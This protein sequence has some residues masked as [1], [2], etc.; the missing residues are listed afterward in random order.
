MTGKRE[1][2]RKAIGVAFVYPL[3]P[4]GIGL[5]LCAGIV[6]SVATGVVVGNWDEERRQIEI[7]HRAE[8]LADALQERLNRDLEALQTISQFQELSQ[9]GN[10]QSFGELT[11]YIRARHRSIET[12]IWVAGDRL[13]KQ[14]TVLEIV[15]FADDPTKVALARARETGEL[16]VTERIQLPRGVRVL[17]LMPAHA[18]P[19]SVSFS[20][21]V[22][23]LTAI[24]DLAKWELRGFVLGILS[25]TDLVKASVSGVELGQ[26]DFC[27]YDE[28]ASMGNRFLAF[29][30]SKTRQV[31]TDS[32]NSSCLSE[33]LDTNVRYLN[34]GDRQWSVLLLPSP[35]YAQKQSSGLAW[36][37]LLSGLLWTSIPVTTL[38]VSLNRTYQREK[39]VQKLSLANSNLSEAN[40]EIIGLNYMS[41]LLQAC[42]TVEEACTVV[43]PLIQSFFPQISGGIFALSDSKNL[44]ESVV[45]W[46]EPF[47]SELV[48]DPD[49][50]LALRCGQPYFVAD[51]NTGLHCGHLHSETMPAEYIDIPMA[52]QGEILGVLHLSSSVPGRLTEGKQRLANIVARQIA[53]AFAN[54]KL[55]ESLKNQSIRDPLTGLFNRRYME[56]SLEREVRR[57]ERNRQSIGIIMLDVDHFK[58]FND[59][60]GHQAGDVLLRELAEFLQACIRVSDIACRYGGEEFTLILPEA[61]LSVTQERAE[62][63]RQGAKALKVEHRQQFLGQISLSL[64]VAIF[65]EH[66]VNGS[67]LLQAAD[68]ALYQAKKEGRDRT[69]VAS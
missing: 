15:A 2:L 3:I 51:C 50:C 55:R 44:V 8:Q 47:S 7:K 52:A 1:W 18:A 10:E 28:S 17:G 54:L 39:L 19:S 11:A 59:T 6:F 38:A 67:S 27:L 23:N 56:E 58:R 42:L 13:P 63:L 46:G 9:Q 37:P 68:A 32:L 64:G 60:F 61:P 30:E 48:F 43:P 24:G 66:G 62:K 41:D 4:T 49:R 14:Q 5:T 22:Q 45:T 33:T 65:P 53:V 26:I 21:N 31:K 16:T 12:L 35:E 36:L 34:A 25:V 20:T 29:Y 69:I 57:A 40:A